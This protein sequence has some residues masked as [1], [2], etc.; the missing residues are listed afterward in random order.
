[1][2]LIIRDS[3]FLFAG[4]TWGWVSSMVLPLIEEGMFRETLYRIVI[5]GDEGVNKIIELAD[6]AALS[7]G[8]TPRIM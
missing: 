3:L 4:E 2:T 6:A 1:M 8:V 7:W 5:Y